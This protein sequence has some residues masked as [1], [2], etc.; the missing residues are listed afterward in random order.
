MIYLITYLTLALAVSFFSLGKRISYLN[1]FFI[2][3]F[4]TP[5][6]GLI[7]VLKTENNILTHHYIT[8]LKCTSC[9]NEMTVNTKECPVCGKKVEVAFSENISLNLA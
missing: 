8:K 4:F 3:L 9:D 5:V 1:V 2:S 7:I 6:I